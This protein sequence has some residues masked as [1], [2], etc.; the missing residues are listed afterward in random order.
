MYHK[1]PHTHCMVWSRTS[2]LGCSCFSEMTR[3]TKRY[4][5]ETLTSLKTKK[6]TLAKVVWQNKS[7][8]ISSD[9]RFIIANRYG[10]FTIDQC[11]C[12]PNETLNIVIIIYTIVGGG[13]FVVCIAFLV[14]YSFYKSTAES[15][16]QQFCFLS[17]RSSSITPPLWSLDCCTGPFRMSLANFIIS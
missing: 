12:I 6:W 4:K 10:K 5:K 8:D 3:I 17:E 9:N 2:K 16:W 15:D 14:F 13:I 1:N 7:V 11:L